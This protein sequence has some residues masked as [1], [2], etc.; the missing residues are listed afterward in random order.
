SRSTFMQLKGEVLKRWLTIGK[1]H[2]HF[3][4]CARVSEPLQIKLHVS[5]FP[6][7]LEFIADDISALRLALAAQALLQSEQAPTIPRVALQVVAENLLGLGRVTEL[8]QRSAERRTRRIGPVG[9]LHVRQRVLGVDGLLEMSNGLRLIIAGFGGFAGEQMVGD[10][11]D[12]GRR[13]LRV[14]QLLRFVA[15]GESCQFGVLARDVV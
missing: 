13:K 15:V 12:A 7:P 2:A 10:S 14:V 11:Q 8:Q 6:R 5:V 3:N 9:W 4:G 1:T